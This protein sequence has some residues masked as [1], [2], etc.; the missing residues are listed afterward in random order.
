MAAK[1]EVEMGKGR[2]FIQRTKVEREVMSVGL[3]VIVKGDRNGFWE[4]SFP[5]E[6]KTVWLE[7]CC[8]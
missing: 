5:V 2:E 8:L 7:L 4:V 1:N 3:M 6:A